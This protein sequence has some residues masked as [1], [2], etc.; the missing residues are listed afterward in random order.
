MEEAGTC[1]PV[2]DVHFSKS[3]IS[4]VEKRILMNSLHLH[5][6][7]DSI[8]DSVCRELK[9]MQ[10]GDMDKWSKR[11]RNIEWMDSK[12]TTQLGDQKLG[13]R[14]TDRAVLICY[15]MV[16]NSQI[17]KKSQYAMRPIL[18]L[19]RLIKFRPPLTLQ[20][21]HHNLVLK[22]SHS[23]YIEKIKLDD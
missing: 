5:G 10:H 1:D 3:I 15:K 6:G 4:I 12:L 14:K 21:I 18:A 19:G 7:L 13:S 8:L 9:K 11:Q 17:C 16:A 2:I 22:Q 23:I 20:Y